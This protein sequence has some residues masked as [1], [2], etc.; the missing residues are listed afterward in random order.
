MRTLAPLAACLLAAASCER[1]DAPPAATGGG[2]AASKGARAVDLSLMDSS[3]KPGDDF[4]LY[5]N[6]GWYGK[7]SIPADRAETGVW[8]KVEEDT[9]ARLKGLLEGA[10]AAGAPAG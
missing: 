6:G 8:L 2:A 3:V 5:A 10:A 9:E 4:F 7:A 1:S